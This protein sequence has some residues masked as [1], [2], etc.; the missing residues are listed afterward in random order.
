MNESQRQRGK[1]IHRQTGQTFYY[2]TRLLPE[3]IREQ[4]YVLYG[5]FRIADEV[6]DGET[7]LDDE[8]KAAELESLRATALGEEPADDPVVD[9][10]SELRARE[11][12]P[13][14]EVN[15]FIDAMLADIGTDRYET[16][17]DLRGYIRGS[18]AAV[19]NM[20]LAIM[21]ADNPGKARPHAMALGE[22]FQL[23]NFIRDVDEDITELDRIYLPMETLEQY[24]VT[25]DQIRRGECTP[26][27][28][29]AIQA[30]LVR[31]ERLYRD[32][33]R[34][35]EH[36]PSDCQFAVLLSAVLYAEH[37]RLI[38]KQEFDVLTSRPSLSRRRKLWLIARTW[39]HW[40]RFRDPV[41]VFER[42]SAIPELDRTTTERADGQEHTIPSTD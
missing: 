13:D 33:V 11:G 15:A 31:T 29:E 7:D 22:A 12:I 37:H 3:R 25:A 14:E 5:F 9:A 34:G 36:L 18:A 32:G 35:I 30:E 27:F 40:R 28:R 17:E 2:A 20:M 10:F 16:F 39:W 26:A 19:G 6:V 1:A 21:D 38:R 23:T 8:E 24:G 42:V 41:A 4:T